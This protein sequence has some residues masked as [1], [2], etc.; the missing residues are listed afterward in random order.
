MGQ[1]FQLRYMNGYGFQ[2]YL[3]YEWGCFESLSGTSVARDLRSSLPIQLSGRAP[4][5]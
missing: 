5:L 1:D 2:K 3:I 4:A